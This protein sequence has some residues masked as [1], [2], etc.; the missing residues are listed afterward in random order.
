MR[1][2]KHDVLFGVLANSVTV[3]LWTIT[4]Y[5]VYTKLE[6]SSVEFGRQSTYYDI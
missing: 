2:H 6:R 1:T 3:R 4:G 5:V